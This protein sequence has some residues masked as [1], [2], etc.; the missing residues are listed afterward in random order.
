MLTILLNTLQQ[1]LIFLPL[2]LGVYLS[3]DVLMIT[4]LT[5][6]GTFV[7]GAAIFARLITLGLNQSI[8]IVAGLIGGAVIGIG[9]T[10]MQRVA[11]IN[12]LIAG[13]LAVFMLY[14]VNFGVMNQ[15]NISLLDN[16]I[17]LQHLQNYHPMVLLFFL[18]GFVF[19]LALF[20]CLFLHSQM[21]LHLRAFGSN[22]HLLKKLGKNPAIYLGIG[23][24]S[25][26]MLAAL[27]GIMTAQVSGYADIHMGLGMAL[28]AIGAVVIGKK[29]LSQLLVKSDRFSAVS[30]MAGCLLGAFIYF[31]ILNGLLIMGINPIYLQL[32][33]G[34]VLVV[35]LSTAHY[36]KQRGE[37]Y[38][39][40]D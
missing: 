25:S 12:S 3:Y 30:G 39:T 38:A 36:T 20:L 28:T 17:F 23:L 31:L 19:L 37:L 33:L 18:I 22:P 5:V 2:A 24:A 34:F 35:F 7:L 40:A 16:H 4:D 13:I 1:T 26:N 21:G 10:V 32:L 11:K 27:C 29:L 14:S 9:V 6:E 15:P 8:S